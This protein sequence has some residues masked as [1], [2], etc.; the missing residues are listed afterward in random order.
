MKRMFTAVVVALALVGGTATTAFAENVPAKIVSGW[1]PWWTS[2]PSSSNPQNNSS[3]TSAVT[4][5][6]LM[7]EVSPFWYGTTMSGG[8]MIVRRNPSYSASDLSAATTT[9]TNAGLRL[10]PSVADG[11]A[12]GQM[13]NVL[14]DPAKRANHIQA[15]VD[16]ANQPGYVGVDLDYERFAFTD[17]SSTWASTQPNWTAFIQELADA[18]HAQGKQLSVTVPPRCSDAAPYPC[19]GNYGYW[20]Y[21][22][23]TIAQYADIIR[24]MA[25]DYHYG[26]PGPIAPI[27]W[28]EAIAAD[29]A[30]SSSPSTKFQIGVPTYGRYWTTKLTG[31]CPASGT[32]EY[33]Q[34]YTS[35]AIDD[36]AIP[37]LLEAV[38]LTQDN[39]TYNETYQESTFTY[40]KAYGDCTAK[41]KVWYVGP[42]G[43]LVRTQLVGKYNLGAA[44]YWTIGGED[45]S[46]WAAI[47]AYAASLGPVKTTITFAPPAALVYGQ[48]ATFAANVNGAG[49]PNVGVTASLQFQKAGKT[50][51]NTIGTPTATDAAGN[52]AF[53]IT[54]TGDGSYRIK[55]PV[56]ANF[57]DAVSNVV[58][59]KIGAK[60]KATPSATKV[61]AKKAF[62]VSVKPTPMVKGQKLKLQQ[63][64]GTTWKTVANAKAPKSGKAKIKASAPKK[65]GPVTY[66]VV[67]MA[68]KLA[69]QGSSAP[70]VIKVK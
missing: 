64:S 10:M 44:A 41:R 29:G 27:A 52:V 60:V 70:F 34:I 5:A 7:R 33:K 9:L 3:V 13:A 58:T 12:K 50:K 36:Y 38:G 28:V 2:M 24:V 63:Q 69:A 23:A 35:G 6:D 42:Q 37:G 20:V 68:T 65:K 61:K 51:W 16:L 11:S 4:N 53:V 46:Q 54:P 32:A 14:A 47:R 26:S 8:Q 62:S 48:Q 19:G 31:T 67:A 25:Y 45:P 59:L 43:V 17:G 49:V 56:N 22:Q 40:T 39:V 57:S 55:V 66:R 18:L 30:A 15:L 1:L 21:N